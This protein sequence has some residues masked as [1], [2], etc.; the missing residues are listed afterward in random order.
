LSGLTDRQTVCVDA[1]RIQAAYN[2]TSE[3]EL[4][5]SGIGAVVE[6][7]SSLFPVGTK[8][9]KQFDGADG[10]LV[11]FEGEVQRYDKQDDIYWILYGD[12]DSED[13]DASEVRDAVGSYRVHVQPQEKAELEA[14]SATAGSTAGSTLL[15]TTVDTAVAEVLRAVGDA[16]TYSCVDC[17]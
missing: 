10:E 15:P 7:S 12:G 16:L 6:P 11:W 9:A 14:E 4:E 3:I 17:R 5:C 8:V 2:N 13:M 1:M